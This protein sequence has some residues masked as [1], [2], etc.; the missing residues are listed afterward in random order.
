ML[1]V[2][3][4]NTKPAFNLAMEEYVLT[5]LKDDMVILWRN[6]PSVIIGRNQNAMAEIDIDFVKENNID[7]IR[8]QSGGGAVFHDLGNINFTI[9]KTIDADKFNDFKEFTEPVVNFLKTLGIEAKLVGRND[10]LIG[11]AKFS[12]NAQ[13]YKN[14]RLMHHGTLLYNA[15]MSFIS[16]S[17]R[18]HPAKIKSRNTASTRSRVTNIA[19]HMSEEMDIEE[20]L[21]RLYDYLLNNMEGIR[22][23]E[24]SSEDIENINKLVDKKYGTWE[25]NIGK[26]PEYD[27]VKTNKF[28]FGIV[29]LHLE[30]ESGLIKKAKIYGDFFGQ[31]EIIGLEEKLLGLRHDKDEVRS[32]LKD[33]DLG[34]YIAGMT[35]EDFLSLV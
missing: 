31:E 14:G 8:R 22:E 3:S 2:N 12:G 28:D 4:E 18:P 19:D 26:A 20:F 11:D 27:I 24:F 21:S 13:S 23:H 9:I 1:L 17:L 32:R 10:L 15:D 30:V 5:Q 35:L 34:V 16:K 7:V 6:A 25:W 29:E 33:V